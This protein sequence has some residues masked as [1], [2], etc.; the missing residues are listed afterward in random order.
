M[1]YNDNGINYTHTQKNRR[2]KTTLCNAI[3]VY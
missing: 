2:L 3:T 1:N